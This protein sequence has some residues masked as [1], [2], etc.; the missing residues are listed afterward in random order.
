MCVVACV[1]VCVASI[2]CFHSLFGGMVEHPSSVPG[3]PYVMLTKVDF[4]SL[5]WFCPGVGGAPLSLKGQAFCFSITPLCL[6]KTE[7]PPSRREAW[8][9]AIASLPL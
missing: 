8:V 4:A 9:L 2:S 3:I 7:V 5:H 1:P 6:D